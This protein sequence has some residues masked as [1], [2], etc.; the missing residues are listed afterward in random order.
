MLQEDDIVPG[1]LSGSTSRPMPAADRATF[2]L[3][4][5]HRVEMLDRYAVLPEYVSTALI[6]AA[7]FAL[8][9]IF[10]S[11][12]LSADRAAQY[13][14]TKRDFWSTASST[15]RLSFHGTAIVNQPYAK[16]VAL[17]RSRH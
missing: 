15:I 10:A 17:V 5:Q 1:A 12:P 13:S 3:R 7:L 14:T 8:V 2:I 6:I 4:C 11:L 16:R 9:V